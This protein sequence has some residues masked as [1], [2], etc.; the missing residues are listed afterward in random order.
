[1]T[2][3]NVKVWLQKSNKKRKICD[4]YVDNITISKLIETETNSKYFDVY[5][6][7]LMRPLVLTLPKKRWYVKTFKVKDEDKDKNN[8]L[9]SFCVDDDKL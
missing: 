5:L 8:K 9:I 6:D 1:M 2:N 4:V 3:H 7:K